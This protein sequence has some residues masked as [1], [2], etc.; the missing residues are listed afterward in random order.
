M[1]TVGP[2]GVSWHPDHSAAHLG[3]AFHCRCVQASNLIVQGDA[4]DQSDVRHCLTGCIGYWM[5]WVFVALQNHTLHPHGF[6]LLG[7]F[8]GATPAFHLGVRRAVDV[9]V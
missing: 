3:A 5:C 6:G 1:L 9:Y 4:A 8:D 7:H 2:G